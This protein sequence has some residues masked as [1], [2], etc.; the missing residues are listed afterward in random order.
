M[1]L[2]ESTEPVLPSFDPRSSL[3]LVVLSQGAFGADAM[4]ITSLGNA[5][6]DQPSEY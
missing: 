2:G 6:S 5:G 4:V 1:G 3:K